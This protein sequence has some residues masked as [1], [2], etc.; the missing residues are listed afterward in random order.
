MINCYMALANNEAISFNY[1]LDKIYTLS[2]F[3]G[4]T[5]L[6]VM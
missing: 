5:L 3:V 4:T 1:L 2:S 6:G